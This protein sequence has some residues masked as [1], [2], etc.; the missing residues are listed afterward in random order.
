MKALIKNILVFIWGILRTKKRQNYLFIMAHTRSGGSLLMHILSSNKEILGYGEFHTSY[1]DN[2]SF[3]RTE[4]DIRR[5]TNQLLRKYEYVANQVN[6]HSIT[7]NINLFISQNIKVIILIRKPEPTLSSMIQ[8]S[9]TTLYPKSEEYLVSRYNRRMED[10]YVMAGKLNPKNWTF[11]RYEDLVDNPDETLLKLSQ[12]LGLA[13]PLKKEYEL[14]KFTQVLGDP[15]TNINKG[16]VYKT[17]SKQVLID[18]ELLSKAM[19]MY[20]KTHS[21]LVEYQSNE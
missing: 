5:K 21:Y 12:Y 8:L 19:K 10:I 7:P 17:S 2:F 20:T 18:K 3:K 1:I 16:K 15:S 9:N 14:K 11:I 4:F 13:E 6:H